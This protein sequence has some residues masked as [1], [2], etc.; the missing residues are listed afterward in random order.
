MQ[1]KKKKLHSNEDLTKQC[2]ERIL[3]PLLKLSL[4]L[5]RIDLMEK[6][7]I[8][9]TTMLIFTKEWTL[10]KTAII[11]LKCTAFLILIQKSTKLCP[12]SARKSSSGNSVCRIPVEKDSTKVSSSNPSSPK[13]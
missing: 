1:R 10:T 2:E 4:R 9:E 8:G 13:T 6:N 5:N 12:R 3:L 7:T 11:Q